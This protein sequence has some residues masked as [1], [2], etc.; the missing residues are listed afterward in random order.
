MTNLRFANEI[1]R[2]LV[3][4]PLR[5]LR[6][7]AIGTG[8]YF[9][10]QFAIVDP[11][12]TQSV[13]VALVAHWAYFGLFRALRAAFVRFLNSAWSSCIFAPPCADACAVFRGCALRFAPCA[14][15][16]S[17]SGL[18]CSQAH[19]RRSLR[20]WAHR[21]LLQPLAAPPL[22]SS[23]DFHFACFAHSARR[24]SVPIGLISACF[25][26]SARPSCALQPLRGLQ[27]A[28]TGTGMHFYASHRPALRLR[29]VPCLRTVPP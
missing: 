23:L 4:A 12:R 14:R 6:R 26:H 7:P 13:L 28:A 2:L 16:S 21:R 19:S 20:H 1:S 3:Y 27:R 18:R 24:S 8:M 11:H 10:P 9:Y 15:H 17:P 22:S 5:E 25:A 29:G